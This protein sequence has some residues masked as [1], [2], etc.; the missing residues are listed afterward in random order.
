MP[1][2]DLIHLAIPFFV[3]LLVLEATISARRGL[4]LFGRRDTF[5]SLGLGLGN[6][7][8]GL[9]WKGVAL[10]GYTAVHQWALFDFGTGALAWVAV[11]VADDFV[12]YWWHRLH[13]E[14]R[15]FWASHVSHHSSRRYNLATAL[16]QSWTSP[17]TGFLFHLPLALLGFEPLLIIAA[18]SINLIY[19]FWIHTRLIDRLGPLEWVLNTPSHHRVH[20]GADVDYLDRNYAGILIVWDRLFG[21][22]EPETAPPHYGL[23]KNVRSYNPVYLAFHE[24][25]AI[26]RDLR[27]APDGRTALAYL[28]APPGW[29]PD[30]STLTA[31]QMRA[32]RAAA[33]TPR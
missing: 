13:H 29:S 20:H 15:F 26:L 18:G 17:F 9:F 2:N 23:T 22:F 16:R 32:A 11:I 27:R 10:A 4:D 21:T 12:Y 8:V 5:A 19:Q 31:A 33:A 30:G 28:F 6:V 3:V 24:F 7:V 14:I 25:A 1:G